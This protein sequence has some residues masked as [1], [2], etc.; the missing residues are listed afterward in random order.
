MRSGR[1]EL[2]LVAQ[3]G[4]RAGD[5]TSVVPF[6]LSRQIT[7][8]GSCALVILDAWV[9]RFEIFA[10]GISYIEIARA[11]VRHDWTGAIN[12]YWSPM[13]SWLCAMVFLTLKPS[14]PWEVAA[15]H[16]VNVIAALAAVPSYEFLLSRM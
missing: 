14:P 11:Y 4:Q 6:T 15:F 13:L 3:G 16:L 12:S 9:R 8:A 2:L 1:A 5:K 7:W 10:D